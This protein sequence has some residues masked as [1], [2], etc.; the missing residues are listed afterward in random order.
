MVKSELKILHPTL[1]NRVRLKSV[2]FI[3]LGLSQVFIALVDRI[4]ADRVA[5]SPIPYPLTGAIF[6]LIGMGIG[7]GLYKGTNTYRTSRLFLA[8]ALVYAMFWEVLLLGSLFTGNPSTAGIVIL[9]GYLTTNLYIILKDVGWEGIAL[10]R[11]VEEE[12]LND[13]N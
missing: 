4:A 10:A 1:F 9:W 3:L 7:Y 11:A 8:A 5:L 12:S 6:I 13:R 2:V